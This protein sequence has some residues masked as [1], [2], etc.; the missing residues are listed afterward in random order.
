MNYY[1]SN[2]CTEIAETM[3]ESIESLAQPPVDLNFQPS[4]PLSNLPSDQIDQPVDSAHTFGPAGGQRH[5]EFSVE[6]VLDRRIKNGKV[7]YLLKWK[8]YSK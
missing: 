3:D 8:G 2:F 6:K 4:Q 7:E 5:E 1:K